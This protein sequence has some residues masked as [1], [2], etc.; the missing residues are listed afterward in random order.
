LLFALFLSAAIWVLEPSAFDRPN[1]SAKGSNGEPAA[2][3]K[4]HPMTAIIKRKSQRKS[5]AERFERYI[6]RWV[7]ERVRHRTLATAGRE[8]IAMAA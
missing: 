5:R 1:V 6:Q 2:H 3:E 8:M 4:C 7:I